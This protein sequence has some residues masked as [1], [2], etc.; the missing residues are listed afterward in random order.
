MLGDPRGGWE[1]LGG[2]ANIK[3][4]ESHTRLFRGWD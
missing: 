1:M 3:M 4:H 2:R